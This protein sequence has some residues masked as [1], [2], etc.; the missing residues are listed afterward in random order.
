MRGS[1]NRR[2]DKPFSSAPLTRTSTEVPACPPGGNTTSRR[3][4]GGSA[5]VGRPRA[6]RPQRT[7]MTRQ[8][9][10]PRLWMHTTLDRA[11]EPIRCR[12]LRARAASHERW[13]RE[14]ASRPR[15]P[16]DVKQSLGVCQ[17]PAEI[18]LERDA[19]P[20]AEEPSSEAN[21]R[22]RSRWNPRARRDARRCGSSEVGRT[23]S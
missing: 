19:G 22:S 6:E 13:F 16:T 4:L 15:P 12:T 20:I 18:S 14:D 9:L 23:S 17:G 5:S 21:S 11:V 1:T 8:Q 2:A 3:G 7:T 10:R